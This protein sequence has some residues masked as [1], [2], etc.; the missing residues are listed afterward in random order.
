MKEASFVADRVCHR[1]PQLVKM[2]S[3]VTVE[4]SAQTGTPTTQLLYSGGTGSIIKEV[5]KG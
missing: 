3:I 4:Y 2:Q 1:D 5:Q